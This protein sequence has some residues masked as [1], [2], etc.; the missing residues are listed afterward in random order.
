MSR[1]LAFLLL[2]GSLL[3]IA[4]AAMHPV[5][6]LTGEGDL[7]L[8]TATP[9]WYLMHLALLY[10]TGLIIVGI[11]ARW[12]SAGSAERLGLGVAC[13]ILGIGQAFNGANIA[14][15]AGAGTR[16]AAMQAGGMDVRAVYQAT[17]GFAVMCG[18]MAGF[19]VAIAAG[20]AAMA[21]AVSATE[22]RW[23]VGLAW[24]ACAAGLMGSLFA[25]PG[26]PLMLT[27]VGLMAAWQ[28]VTAVRVL[29]G[30]RS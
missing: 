12:L 11:W 6:P 14:F 29:R 5:L 16:F 28:V 1:L 21:T 7:A 24:L 17:H 13:V 8:I 18:R 15:M 27:S 20:L 23:L 9:H 19:L 25:A 2:I 22:P 4:C 26:H 3:L 30:E 10:A